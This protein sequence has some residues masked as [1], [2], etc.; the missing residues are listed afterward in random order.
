MNTHLL[1]PRRIVLALVSVGVIGAAGVGALS[2]SHAQAAIPTAPMT[3]TAV[4]APLMALP[5]FA[6]ITA[7]NGAAVVNISVTNKDDPP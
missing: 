4:A 1:T 2:F 7:R 6:Q 3:A 5:D